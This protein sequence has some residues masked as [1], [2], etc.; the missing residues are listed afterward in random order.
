MR[1]KSRE[2]ILKIAVGVVVGLFVLDRMVLNPAIAAWKKQS[3]R[4]TT[5]R[6]DVMRGRQLLERETSLRGRWTEM[7][8]TDLDDDDSAAEDDVYKAISRWTRASNLSFTSLTPDPREHE[9][10]DTFEF[11]AS[12]NGDQ[13]A[14]GRLLYELETDPLPARVVECEMNARDAKGQQLGLTLK[15]SF[16]RITENGGNG[17]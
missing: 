8:R 1:D 15:F 16:V 14:F 17:R 7:Q 11:R 2:T 6:R 5:L 13:A 9:G 4:L 10:Y 12:A 3:E